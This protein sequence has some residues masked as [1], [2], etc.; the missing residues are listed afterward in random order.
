MN[1]DMDI[2]TRKV[3]LTMLKTQGSLAVSDMAEQLGVTEMAV[4]RH[5]NT[6]ERDGLIQARLVRQAMGRPTKLYSLTEQAD[7]LFPKKY[8][9]LALDL[10]AE[11]IE[12]AGEEQVERLFERRKERLIERYQQQM[13]G[14]QLSERVKILAE[15]QNA[16]GYM[17][18]WKSEEGDRYVI[19]EHNCPITKVANQYKYAC[20]C[21]LKM[22]QKL[23]NADVERT[24]CLA[25]G[26]SKCSYTIRNN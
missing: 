16:N 10:L 24:E 6:L 2:S 9:H 4:R 14:Q 25:K 23:L 15:I 3:I 5:L 12:E 8:K 18:E 13:D 7:D 11:L 17:V 22:F 1:Q 21:E 26:G 19:D 20:N